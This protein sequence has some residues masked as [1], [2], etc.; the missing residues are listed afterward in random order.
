MYIYMQIYVS[1]DC[2]REY[3]IAFKFY[4]LFPTEKVFSRKGVRSNTF[5]L[6]VPLYEI[7]TLIPGFCDHSLFIVTYWYG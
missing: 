2:V 5:E 7:L 3:E 4:I 1:T 6:N